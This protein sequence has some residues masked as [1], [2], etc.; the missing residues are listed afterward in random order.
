MNFYKNVLYL[1]GKTGHRYILPIFAEII[2]NISNVSN[3]RDAGNSKTRETQQGQQQQG[4]PTTA[5][6][7]KTAGTTNQNELLGTRITVRTSAT[8]GSKA[9]QAKSLTS[10][11]EEHMEIPV[12]ER[13]ST[14][15]WEPSRLKSRE[16]SNCKQHSNG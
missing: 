4:K 5:V 16:A 6:T 7:L 1:L 15:V 12:A 9:A 10:G 2:R 3:S 8:V 14:S 13:T 11:T